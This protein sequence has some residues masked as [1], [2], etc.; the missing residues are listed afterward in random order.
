MRGASRDFA[1]RSGLA[2]ALGG[3]HLT[4]TLDLAVEAAEATRDA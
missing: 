3:D 2:A 4:L 1:E